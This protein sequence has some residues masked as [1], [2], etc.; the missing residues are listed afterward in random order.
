MEENFFDLIKN[1]LEHEV[2]G[3]EKWLN[4]LITKSSHFSQELQNLSSH[5]NSKS[6]SGLFVSI[7]SASDL[8]SHISSIF[9]LP[10]Y[11]SL[12]SSALAGLVDEQLVTIN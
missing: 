12:F 2:E 10:S 1:E 6:Q 3:K 9:P 11:I 8:L 5:L 4:D 7:S